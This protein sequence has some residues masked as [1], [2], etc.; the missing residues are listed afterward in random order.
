MNYVT[1]G[2]TPPDPDSTVPP[3]QALAT[4]ANIKDFTD[5]RD[6]AIAIWLEN[7]DRFHTATAAAGST[8]IAGNL[9]LSIPQDDR[10]SDNS[11]TRAFL[12]TG[13]AQRWDKA[14]GRQVAYNARDEFEKL[15]TANIDRRCWSHLMEHLG[16]DT[17]LD[18]QAR[19]EFQASIRDAP[20]AFTVENANATFSTVWANRREMYLR[21]IA[22]V[23]MK[24]DRRFRSHDAFAIGNRL[25]FSNA[26]AVDYTGWSHYGDGNKRDA[27]GDVERIFREL[28]G[29]GPL[30][31]GQQVSER[32]AISPGARP[33]RFEEDYFKIDVFKNGNIHLWFTRKDLLAKV[34][35]LLLEYYRPVEGDVDQSAPGYDAGPLYHATPAKHY[36]FFPSPEPVVAQ[37]MARAEMYGRAD[38]AGQMRDEWKPSRVLEPSAGTGALAAA[39]RGKGHDVTCIEIQPHLA[40]LL[41]TSGYRTREGDFLAMQP[42]DLGELFDFVIMNPPFDRG[43]DCDHVRHALKFLRP[44][45]RLVAV[46]SA[47]AEH[48][49]DAR[50]KA[51]HDELARL[52][53][54]NARWIDL[55]EKSFA[56]AGTNVNTVILDVRNYR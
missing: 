36:G 15:L 3:D 33:H 34:N 46:M 48:A 49:T 1:G 41:R 32:I 47:R 42:S 45:G 43:R 31:R 11:F 40:S 20:P 26:L 53:R 56:L 8:C 30:P 9:S 35:E 13:Q 7:Y 10:Y 55:P 24:M 38:C 23:F 28:D 16:F 27:L 44:G 5:G 14:L 22:N 6:R 18:S 25:I 4:L 52:G 2:F 37:V 29:K 54:G 21:G 12:T 51:L 19:S 39:A 17:L 50:H